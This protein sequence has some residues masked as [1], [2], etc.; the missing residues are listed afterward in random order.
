VQ[1]K[2]F[3]PEPPRTRRKHFLFVGRYRQ[4]KRFAW[5]KSEGLIENRLSPE[6]FAVRGTSPIRNKQILL[7]ALCALCERHTVIW[8]RL[9]HDVN[10]FSPSPNRQQSFTTNFY[11]WK[12]TK[13]SGL[14]IQQ[15]AL[16][17]SCQLFSPALFP[18]QSPTRLSDRTQSPQGLI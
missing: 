15:T 5:G 11:P 1:N 9:S 6:L 16:S 7:C 12:S 14:N 3:T 8:L 18:A 4:T 13:G 10:L 17:L 2:S